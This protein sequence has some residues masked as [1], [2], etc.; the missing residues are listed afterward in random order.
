MHIRDGWQ[1]SRIEFGFAVEDRLANLVKMQA[2]NMFM[3]LAK[4]IYR[5][6]TFFAHG[7]TNT[8]EGIPGFPAFLFINARAIRGLEAPAYQ[9]YMG[10]P[11][12]LLWAVPITQ[13]EYDFEVQNG[14]NALLD[15]AKDI[16]RIHIFDGIPKFRI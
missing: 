11:I 2:Y 1:H 5:D 14:V 10:D 13:Q 6:R 4:G 8:W 9:P 15:R 7:H 16:L 12:N 3:A